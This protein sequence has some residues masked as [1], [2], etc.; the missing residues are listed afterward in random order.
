[1]RTD[2]AVS[3]RRIQTA[4]TV[5]VVGVGLVLAFILGLYGYVIATMKPLHPNAQGLK[6]LPE[7]L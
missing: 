4:L 3:K 2:G 7:E 1:L 6:P 5:I